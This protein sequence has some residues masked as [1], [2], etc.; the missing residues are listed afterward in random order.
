LGLRSGVSGFYLECAV[1]KVKL[2]KRKREWTWKG[3]ICVVS[4]CD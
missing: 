3:Y 4:Y 2:R 1:E